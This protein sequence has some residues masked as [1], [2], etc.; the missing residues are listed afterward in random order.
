MTPGK[1]GGHLTVLAPVDAIEKGSAHFLRLRDLVGGHALLEVVFV[2]AGRLASLR[3]G[4]VQPGIAEH[5]ILRQTTAVGVHHA[6][7]ELSSGDT[8]IGSEP[9]PVDGLGSVFQ[10][11]FAVGIHEAEVGLGIGV[12]LIGGEPEPSD[13]LRIV[14]R[15]GLAGLVHETEVGLG[16]GI[17]LL[18]LTPNFGGRIRV[19]SEHPRR[20]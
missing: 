8:L 2:L 1:A 20:D 10:Y 15:H 18:G 5:V 7:V 16:R 14:F 12:P 13:G 9:E 6:K 11:P 17:P 4:K 3:G 19:L